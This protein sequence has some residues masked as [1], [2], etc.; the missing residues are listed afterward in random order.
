MFFA[1]FGGKF[2]MHGLGRSPS[3]ITAT[4]SS[5]ITQES[6]TD[7]SKAGGGDRVSCAGGLGARL[8][9]GQQRRG[10]IRVDVTADGKSWM[11]ADVRHVPQEWK[12]AAV[13]YLPILASAARHLH[14]EREAALPAQRH[15]FSLRSVLPIYVPTPLCSNSLRGH[16][17]FV[18]PLL[19]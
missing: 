3:I 1:V 17:P 15:G 5:L 11:T 16:V 14:S 6:P 4:S 13:G 10:V 7:K 9:L 19:Q 18:I 12:G 8:R 2:P